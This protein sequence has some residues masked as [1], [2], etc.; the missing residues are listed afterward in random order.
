MRLEGFE[1]HIFGYRI[2]NLHQKEGLKA[3][4]GVPIKPMAGR[5]AKNPKDILDSIG[6]SIDKTKLVADYKYDG[7]RS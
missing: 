3:I 7:E 6:K 2:L 5:A 1:Q 4:Y